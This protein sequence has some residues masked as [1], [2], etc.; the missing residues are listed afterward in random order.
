[1][2]EQCKDAYIL[3]TNHTTYGFRVMETGQLEHLYYGKRITIGDPKS[4]TEKHAFAPGNTINYDK[5]HMDVALE[6]LCLEVS[7]YGKGDIREPFVEVICADGSNTTDFVFQEAKILSGKEPFETLPSSYYKTGS[8][9]HLLVI[10]KDKNHGLTLELHYYV[11]EDCDVITRSSRLINTS[12]AP[13]RLE[14]LM[15]MQ[16]DFPDTG[17]VVTS[18]HGGW[19]REMEKYDTPVHIGRFVNASYTGT[20]SN[21]CNPFF[22]VSE[23]G[24]TEEQGN[25]FGFNLIYSGNH[26]EAI[27]VSGF[28]KTR[29]ISGINP[30][31]FAFLL[32]PGACF[33]APEAVM[34]FSHEGHG[35][36]SRHMHDFVREHIVR[37]TWKDRERPV[38][39]N[40]WEASYFNISESSLL[41]LARE[42]KEVGIE[43]FV[44]DDGWFGERNDDLR[45]LGDWTP[46][47]KKLP[48]GLDGICRRINGL[49]ME[50]GI[51]IEPE[52]VNTDS[53][54]YR[55]HPDWS[56]DIPGMDHAEG[57]N[58]RILDFCNPQVVDYMIDQMKE[59]LSSANI[60]YVKWDMNRIFSDYYSRYLQ[61]E[62]QQEVAH[63]YICGVYRLAKALTEAF[64]DILFEGCASGGNRFDLGMLCY[65][66]QIWASDN[67]DAV[68][69]LS[70]QNG[71][72]YGYPMSVV[73]AHVSSC[74]N[75]QTLRVTPLESRFAVA[76]FGILGYECNLC[77]MSPKDKEQIKEQIALYKKYR[78][79]WQQGDFYRVRSGNQY[80]WNV[81][82]KDQKTAIGMIMQREV[83]P[84]TP[85]ADFRARGLAEDR[86]YHF[87]GQ[88]RQYNIKE[89]GDLM[90]A[91]SPIHIRPE[92]PLHNALAKVIHIDG[93]T[94]DHVCSG[95]AIMAGVKLQPAFAGTGLNQDV[96][97]FPDFASRLYFM[98]EV[99]ETET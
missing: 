90:N 89:F 61:P 40:S 9:G 10:L 56:V 91:V 87:F 76:S 27:E 16:L 35:G 37:G 31:N 62:H 46:N 49:G 6:D 43:L 50:F 64:P 39:L 96:R 78:S 53:D 36:M 11:F 30:T 80:Q 77:D 44:M 17:Y 14:R 82:S 83:Q 28:G 20:S 93:E 92:S 26:Y 71:Y 13:L 69:R 24:T 25:C 19:A 81:V 7:G 51:W 4:L 45:S 48:R 85:F 67:T 5:E 21:R 55:K 60:S 65:F 99:T 41:R 74:P 59:V 57:R 42:A 52:M 73:S 66:P 88:S 58:Q 29:V 3:S 15:S 1:M 33:E 63:R 68:S 86:Q 70:I 95:G 97:H 54:L 79:T 12:S 84:N 2:I 38:L 72:S 98:E 32:E 23:P 18:F 94:E 8:V 47:A 75:H 34:T 22:M